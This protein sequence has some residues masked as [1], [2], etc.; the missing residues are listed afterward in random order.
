MH[1]EYGKSREVLTG[2]KTSASEL[3]TVGSDRLSLFLLVPTL[4]GTLDV[5]VYAGSTS[6]QVAAFPTQTAPSTQ[7]LTLLTPIL[8]GPVRIVVTLTGTGIFAISGKAVSGVGAADSG[9]PSA[10]TGT[11]AHQVLDELIL[12]NSSEV[13]LG[14]GTELNIRSVGQDRYLSIPDSNSVDYQ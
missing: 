14:D 8:V 9:E 10:G 6:I 12:G 3:I 2:D 5:V 13:R 11:P 7:Y 1:I 4:T